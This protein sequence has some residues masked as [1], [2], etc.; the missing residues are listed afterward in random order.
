MGL[1]IYEKK[2]HDH[3]S[4]PDAITVP[5]DRPYIKGDCT[6]RELPGRQRMKKWKTFCGRRS[7]E[8]I[9]WKSALS[10][11]SMGV[12]CEITSLRLTPRYGDITITLHNLKKS[13]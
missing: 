11:L 13:G 12:L 2:L 8:D 5:R 10:L 9:L 6:Q 1:C 7:V 3:F 4:G